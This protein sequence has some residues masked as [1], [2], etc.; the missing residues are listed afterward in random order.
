M[1]N[2]TINK[3]LERIGAQLLIKNQAIELA[4]GTLIFEEDFRREE[5]KYP[6]GTFSI[7]DFIIEKLQE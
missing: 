3:F 5:S 7:I 4:D 2:Y 6:K 1:S